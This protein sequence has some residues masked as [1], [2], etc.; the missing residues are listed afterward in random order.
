MS[1][2]TMLALGCAG[3]IFCGGIVA[4]F[5]VVGGL[6][7]VGY[8]MSDVDGLEVSSDIPEIIPA[9]ERFTLTVSASNVGEEAFDIT[10]IDFVSQHWQILSV[11]AVMPQTTGQDQTGDR[12]SFDYAQSLAAGEQM[13]F[14]FVGVADDPVTLDVEVQVFSG[15][16]YTS[17]MVNLPIANVQ[18]TPTTIALVETAVPVATP[19]EAADTQ[20]A[21]EITTDAGSAEI[22]TTSSV[23]IFAFYDDP[24]DF[25]N[26]GYWHGSG[27]IVTEDGLILTNA[28]V[29]LPDYE[30]TPEA[31]VVALTASA[32]E[33]P[34]PTYVAEIV[35]YDAYLDLAVIR[36]TTD[37]N[38][39]PIDPNSLNLRPVQFGD[40]DAINLGDDLLILGYPGIGGE[41]ITATTGVVAGFTQQ[42]GVKGRAFIKTNATMAGGVSGGMALDE[43]NRVIGIP[44]ELGSGSDDTDAVDCRFLADTNGDGSIDEGDVCVPTGGFINALRPVNL[45]LPLIAEAKGIPLSDL[46][47]SGSTANA[48]DNVAD[49]TTVDRTP[50]D[51]SNAFGFDTFQ[52][53]N[54]SDAWDYVDEHTRAEVV[55]GLMEVEIIEAG[56][57]SNNWWEDDFDDIYLAVDARQ[58]DGVTGDGSMSLMC[59]ASDADN[60]YAFDIS[61]DGWFA[62]WKLEDNDWSSL[63]EWT[64]AAAIKQGDAWNKIQ[65]ACVG[66]DLSLWVNDQFLISIEDDTFSSGDAG[67]AA[68]S[69]EESNTNFEFD[70]F[71]L[72]RP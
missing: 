45:A 70:N 16:A 33:P 18:P 53:E 72:A 64:Q 24:L 40:S 7:A 52:G 35:N 59:R 49:E 14:E 26:G 43:Q 47:P 51:M 60:M 34:V 4:L 67:F 28:H 57:I 10:E 3:L 62:I 63:V 41:T 27:S 22:P 68:G 50:P 17:T 30:Y 65:V 9:G 38:G 31:L 66:N 19:E 23:Q 56:W 12:I 39:N 13:T 37:L 5:F 32:D 44:T 58:V 61:N 25:E 69:F 42:R 21:A 54:A 6:G 71:Q 29:V 8:L 20:A 15:L 36:V 2:N 48:Q 46:V 55:N 1:R 11:E